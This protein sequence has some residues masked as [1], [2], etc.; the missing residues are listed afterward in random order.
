MSPIEERE[1]T[2]DFLS[3]YLLKLTSRLQKSNESGPKRYKVRV[4]DKDHE[5]LEREIPG[6]DPK[7]EW[8][9][10][11]GHE[12]QFRSEHRPRARYLNY[13]FCV[14]MLRRFHHHLIVKEIITKS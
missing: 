11:D 8:A 3:L 13:E 10:L 6:S 12:L 7:M 5:L 14:S 4:L 9:G 2:R 1:W